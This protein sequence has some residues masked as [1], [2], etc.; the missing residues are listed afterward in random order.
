[1][2]PG[3]MSEPLGRIHLDLP[4]AAG[5]A[6]RSLPPLDEQAG[7]VVYELIKVHGAAWG[8]HASDQ[9]RVLELPDREGTLLQLFSSSGHQQAE[10]AGE[11]FMRWFRAAEEPLERAFPRSSGYTIEPLVLMAWENVDAR[12]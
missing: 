4:V 3:N 7:L 8:Y 10:A 12:G 11:A 5:V 1:M 6:V 9:N 2:R